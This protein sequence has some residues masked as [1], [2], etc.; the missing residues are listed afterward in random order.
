MTIISTF[1]KHYR[2]CSQA[3]RKW[4]IGKKNNYLSGPSRHCTLLADNSNSYCW[5]GV[6][7]TVIGLKFVAFSTTHVHCTNG[8]SWNERCTVLIF[9]E[10]IYCM[11]LMVHACMLVTLSHDCDIKYTYWMAVPIH[12][13]G[14]LE[15]N[16][17][18]K[19]S[20]HEAKFSMLQL[21]GAV[22]VLCWVWP[23]LV[24]A[25]K[26]NIYLGTAGAYAWVMMCNGMK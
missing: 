4:I 23:T 25:I 5:R 10:Q 19:K 17:G 26:C 7:Y 22:K 21:G 8:Q 15:L 6:A 11:L 18:L 12:W 14:L 9:S 20:T 3:L 2:A 13:T 1:W 24:V 16:T